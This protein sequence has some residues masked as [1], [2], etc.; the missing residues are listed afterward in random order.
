MVK[1]NKHLAVY[2]SGVSK[3]WG[4]LYNHS[5]VPGLFMPL[6]GNPPANPLSKQAL[7]RRHFFV[8]MV[9]LFKRFVLY[10]SGHMFSRFHVE[11]VELPSKIKWDY[12]HERPE[13]IRARESYKKSGLAEKV[14]SLHRERDLKMRVRDNFNSIVDHFGNRKSLAHLAFCLYAAGIIVF[15]INCIFISP[16]YELRAAYLVPRVFLKVLINLPWIAAAA[17]G[18][19]YYPTKRNR[20]LIPALILFMIGDI[21]TL[22]SFPLGGVFYAAG[23]IFMLVAIVE[24]TYIRNWQKVVLAVGI[25]AAVVVPLVLLDNRLFMLAAMA[26][27]TIVTTVMAFSLSNRFFCLAGI[28]FYLSD[29]TGVIRISLPG[30]FF[31]GFVSICTCISFSLASSNTSSSVVM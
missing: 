30:F 23:H 10:L 20:I 19:K 18:A 21:G 28:I 27:G 26:Y 29:F 11:T 3:I 8:N 24:T 5:G 13:I 14:L 7:L 17:L 31:D 15:I 4:F 12:G 9:D 16:I 1:I 25:A 6:M 2:S 22:F